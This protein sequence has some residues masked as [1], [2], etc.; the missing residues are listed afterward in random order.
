MSPKQEHILRWLQR[1]DL[2]DI[3]CLVEGYICSVAVAVTLVYPTELRL[4]EFHEVILADSAVLIK[5]VL[6]ISLYTLHRVS[7]TISLR[8]PACL[9]VGLDRW[10]ASI[11]RIS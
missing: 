9:F 10:L 11:G 2:L 8:R 4:T 7:T 5:L 3:Q 6:S 1:I